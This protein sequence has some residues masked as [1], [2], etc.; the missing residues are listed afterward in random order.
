MKA[1]QCCICLVFLF[2]VRTGRTMFIHPAIS[3]TATSFW[4]N[5]DHI[6]AAL[7]VSPHCAALGS[8][9]CAIPDG[10]VQFPRGSESRHMTVE[11][12]LFVP[13]RVECLQQHPCHLA[14]PKPALC[15]G[16][17]L[18]GTGN[19]RRAAI[20]I[21]LPPPSKPFLLSLLIQFQAASIDNPSVSTTTL[22]DNIG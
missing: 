13:I 5:L 8:S 3:E 20:Y 17:V 18:P 1:S 11:S 2:Q 9:S 10:W 22:H 15:S 14:S 16:R 19:L 7:L 4:S 6:C 12:R 21:K